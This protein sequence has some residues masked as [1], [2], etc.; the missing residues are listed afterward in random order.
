MGWT[1]SSKRSGTGEPR[2]WLGSAGSRARTAEK[3]AAAADLV[4]Q[5]QQLAAAAEARLTQQ[6]QGKAF[7]S[8]MHCLGIDVPKLERELD[9]GRESG[10]AS[11]ATATV[12]MTTQE[13]VQAKAEAAA[14]S[15]CDSE[16]FLFQR[17]IGRY[18]LRRSWWTM[19]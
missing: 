11:S 6:L 7:L 13:V 3:Q 2:A 16:D 9:E 5:K 15:G 19:Q 1:P 4:A 18:K 17:T 12:V 8:A 10:S 14:A